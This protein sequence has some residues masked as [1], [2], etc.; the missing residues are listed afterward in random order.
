VQEVLREGRHVVYADASLLANPWYRTYLRRR[1]PALPEADKPLELMGKIW[2][3]PA[4]RD[5]PIYLA[6]TFS[7]P[8]ADL[9]CVPEGILWRV[10]SPRMRAE[11]AGGPREVASRHLRAMTRYLGVAP[12]PYAGHPWSGDLHHAYTDGSLQLA[13]ALRLE[14]RGALADQVEAH[15][16]ATLARARRDPSCPWWCGLRGREGR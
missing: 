3:D 15:L 10:L 1:W 4:L 2:A 12:S 13:R 14:G 8:S 11:G 5:T 9:A 16:R 6:N 7:R